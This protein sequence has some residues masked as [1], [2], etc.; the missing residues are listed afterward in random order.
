[1]NVS[2]S[3]KDSLRPIL[4]NGPACSIRPQIAQPVRINPTVAVSRGPRRNAAHSRGR[5]AKKPSG[6][7]YSERGNSGLNAIRPTA[8]ADS[9]DTVTAPSS[10]ASNA[11][12]SDCAHSTI[13]GVTTSAPAASPSHHVIQIGVNF[14]QAAKPATLSVRTPTVALMTGRRADRDKR[15]LRHPPRAHES[16]APARPAPDQVAAGE[17]FQCIAQRNDGGRGGRP[18][19]G[20]IGG[21]GANDDRRPHPQ[22]AQQDR[23]Q[24]K[25]GRRPDRAGA[26]IDRS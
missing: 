10:R 16:V 25:T 15:E 7:V 14:V 11:R 3:R 22:A 13:T 4:P 21:E 12:H 8:T 5:I 20:D 19:R 24:R 18:G 26:W 9:S 17:R 2:N 23:R 6:L 1:M